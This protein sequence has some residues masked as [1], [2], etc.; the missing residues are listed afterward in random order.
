[1]SIGEICTRNVVTARRAT[2]LTDASKLMRE[3]HVGCVVVLGDDGSQAPTGILTD[4]DIVVE[5]VAEG[6]DYRGLTVGDIVGSQL[7]TA[8]EEDSAHDTLMTLRRRGIRRMPV[9]DAKGELAGIVTLDDLL[10]VVASELNNLV[11]AIGSEQQL[12]GWRRP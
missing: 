10:G 8:R 12:E 5:V 11:V 6:V 2:T 9:I 4:R 1:M 7:I 3:N